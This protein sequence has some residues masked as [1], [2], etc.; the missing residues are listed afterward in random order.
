MANT[1]L[2]EVRK[3]YPEYDY[4][5]DQELAD[6]LHKKFYS[7]M[8]VKDF[9]ERVGLTQPKGLKGVAQDINKSIQTIPENLLEM[10]KQMPGQLGGAFYQATHE[11]GRAVKNVFA[12]LGQGGAGLLNTPANI[13]DY[14]AEK[15]L[16][17]Q[18]TP[19]FRLSESVLPRNYNYAEGVGIQGEIPGDAFL[20]GIGAAAPYIA[21]GELGALGIPARM[22][23]RA[24]AQGAFAVGQN[25]D[26]ITAA[27]TVPGVEIP[28]R[29]IPALYNALKPTNLFRGN[30]SLEELMARLRAAEGTNTDLGNIIGSPTLKGIFENMTTKWPGS[31]ADALLGRMANQVENRGTQILADIGEGLPPGDLNAILKRAIESAHEAQRRAKNE[32]YQPVNNL[33]REENFQVNLPTFR[34][35]VEQQLNNI[36]DSPLLR[37]D[38]D[39]R[40]Q[41]RRLAGLAEGFEESPSILDVN[42]AASKFEN[43]GNTLLNRATNAND[44]AIGNL[45]L[46]LSRRLYADLNNQ[47]RHASPELRAAYDAATENYRENYSQFLDKDV[48]KWTRPDTEAQTIVNDIIQPSKQGDKYSR[49]EKIQRLLPDDMQSALGAAWLR[50]ALDKE[51]NLNPKQFAQKLEQLGPRQFEALFPNPETR[52][53]LL[54]YGRL[55][56]MNE[57]ALSRMAN[58]QTGATLGVPGMIVGQGAAVGSAL[59]MGNYPKA[60]AYAVGPQIGSN[61]INRLLTNPETRTNFITRMLENETRPPRIPREMREIPFL[62]T[63]N[64]DVYE[65]R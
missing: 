43:E 52:T 22:A 33:A 6:N 35:R 61:L 47:M 37:Y 11:P 60:I 14:L 56:G 30:L 4:M 44:R 62:S 51:G 65:E 38:N 57:K 8:P 55:R 54:D 32:L 15:E 27:A 36:E 19:S 24:G 9:Y 53:A 49:I 25:Q 2:S 20:Q 29:S 21:G 46:D 31:G 64:Y 28:L 1:I 59:T 50:G 41:Y 5:P 34:Q 13:R 16:I 63:Q 10:V 42:M 23:S 3:A 17:P 45:Y 40:N 12:G 18:E 26:P 39:F 58:P 48:W 7:N